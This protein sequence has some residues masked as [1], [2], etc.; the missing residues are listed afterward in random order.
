MNAVE[1]LGRLGDR[2]FDRLRHEAAFT[3]TDEAA[4]DGDFGALRGHSYVLL[5]T[6]RR[7][8]EAVPSPVWFALDAAGSVLVKTR[9]DAGKVKRVRVDSRVLVAPCNQR[10]K[11]LGP[12]IRA[13]GGLLAAEEWRRAEALL[14]A[15]YGL[16]RKL[17]D[18][19]LGGPDEASAYLEITPGR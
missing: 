16:G 13:T 5:V 7:N 12:A 3:V 10:G 2:V 17:S 9:H 15:A 14:A 19:M 11:P 6:F 4:I 18:G 1:R 8:G